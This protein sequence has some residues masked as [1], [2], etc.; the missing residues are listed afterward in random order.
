MRALA[1]PARRVL[2]AAPEVAMGMTYGNPSID[3]ALQAFRDRGR[4]Q[5]L[6]VLPLF[7]QYSATTTAAALDRVEAALAAAGRPPELP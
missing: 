7:P 1:T 2:P 5:R 6:V 3:S 4:S